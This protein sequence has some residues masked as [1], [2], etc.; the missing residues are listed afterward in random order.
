M[1]I[2]IW[3]VLGSTILVS[4][5]CSAHAF[6]TLAAVQRTQFH[7]DW[8]SDGNPFATY[9]TSGLSWGRS[10][11]AIGVSAMFTAMGI[12]LAAAMDNDE[13]DRC[14]VSSTPEGL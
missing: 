7:D 1:W 9:F 2:V 13:H 8:V 12:E 5:I 10:F 4:G 11:R 14:T 3:S 6:D